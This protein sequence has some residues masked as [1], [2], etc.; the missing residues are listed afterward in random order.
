MKATKYL[1][2]AVA[3]LAVVTSTLLTSPPS[4]CRFLSA[5]A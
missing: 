2:A 1:V 4:A 3:G 5:I